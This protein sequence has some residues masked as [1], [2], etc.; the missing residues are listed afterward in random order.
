MQFTYEVMRL[1]QRPA[2]QFLE[3]G[4]GTLPLATLCRMPRNASL[5]DA[6]PGIIRQ[7]DERL[8]AE[9]TPEDARKLLM[10]AYVL[11]GLRMPRELAAQL[12]GGLRSMRESSTYQAILEEGGIDT[13]R[14]MLLR[15]GRIKFGPCDQVTE[16]T[17]QAIADIGQLEQL[18]ERLLLVS[19]WQELL[20][21]P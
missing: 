17:I 16:Q 13:L 14:R 3:G 19:S 1:W 9:T 10:A 12:F 6:L 11:T 2:K 4:L 15:Q 18:T 7:I 8:Q 5:E 20:Q 21:T